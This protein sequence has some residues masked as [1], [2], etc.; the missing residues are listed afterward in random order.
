[1]G[2]GLFIGRKAELREMESILKPQSNTLG[3]S[4]KVLILG[5]M[6]GIGKTQLAITYAKRHRT[7]Y[8]T[9]FWLNANTEGTLNNSFRALAN[10]ILS[11]EDVGKLEDDQLCL[12][13]SN[14]LSEQDNT[15][16]LLI[17][18]NYDEPGRYQIQK[19]YPSVGNGSIIITTRQPY[20]V[21]GEIMKI[22]VAEIEDG[23]H[24]L[25]TR[26]GRENVH[27]GELSTGN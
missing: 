6:G 4:R 12:R 8:K 20:Q 13:V 18:D 9:T 1:M 23:L 5:G 7:S 14:W 3:S 10:R 17:F 11:P 25:A 22:S 26:S 21:N 19:Y 27:S 15:R 16:W 2:E 24:I